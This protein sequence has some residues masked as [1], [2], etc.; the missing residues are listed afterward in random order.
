M[1]PRHSDP[2]KRQRGMSTVEVAVVL[3]IAAVLAA[4][5]GVELQGMLD[6]VNLDAAA[7]E[8]ITDLRYARS[9]AVRE[10]RPVYVLLDQE[11][12]LLTVLRE[13]DPPQP[14]RPGRDLGRQGVRSLRSTGGKLLSFNPRGTSATAT[15]LTLEGRRG[16]QR[17]V[18]VGLTGIV[19]AR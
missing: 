14:V 13:I 16:D 12:L 19:R 7:F 9:C 10:R 18:T 4:A 2:H 6:H 11:R 8:V 17:V 15:T 1:L 5:L 3:C